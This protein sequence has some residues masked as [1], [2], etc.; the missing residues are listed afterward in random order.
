MSDWVTKNLLFPFW[1]KFKNSSLT[2][3]TWWSATVLQKLKE[4]QIQHE[5]INSTS[6]NLSIECIC[7]VQDFN[8]I[9]NIAY[10]YK[11]GAA[12]AI[13]FE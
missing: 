11:G 7:S 4:L 6:D 3:E 1:V 2:D 8:K 9:K 10:F 13:S 5:V 12:S